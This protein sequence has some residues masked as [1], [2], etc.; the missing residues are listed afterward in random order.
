MLQASLWSTL[1]L[2]KINLFLGT[3]GGGSATPAVPSSNKEL[4][5]WLG[6]S[7]PR[8]ILLDK[9]IGLRLHKWGSLLNGNVWLKI[10]DFTGTRTTST[11]CRP[12]GCSPTPQ[13]AIDP[14][15]WYEYSSHS[16]AG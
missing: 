4:E 10:Y 15:G 1:H 2:N 7:V 5:S 14:T 6:D 8:V 3:T 12:W 13:L 11:G 16:T 9:V